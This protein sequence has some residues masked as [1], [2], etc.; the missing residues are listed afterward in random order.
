MGAVFAVPYWRSL[1][2][3]AQL[4]RDLMAIQST[5]LSAK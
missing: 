2:N 5:D 4:S 3:V 1:I